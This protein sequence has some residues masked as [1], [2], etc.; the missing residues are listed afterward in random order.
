MQI[1]YMNFG[2][3]KTNILPNLESWFLAYVFHIELEQLQ[4]E[5]DL[6]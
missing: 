1:H 6:N 4:E 2:V 3:L 5:N